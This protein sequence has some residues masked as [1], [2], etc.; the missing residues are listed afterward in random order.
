LIFAA[1]LR[2]ASSAQA[3]RVALQI[4]RRQLVFAELQR[5]GQVGPI[6]FEFGEF[7]SSVSRRLASR[8]RFF[9]QACLLDLER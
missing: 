9:L 4:A 6:A 2:R 7:F 5:E 1:A 3:V 8:S